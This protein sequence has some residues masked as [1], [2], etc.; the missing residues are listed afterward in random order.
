MFCGIGPRSCCFVLTDIVIDY[1]LAARLFLKDNLHKKRDFSTT[2]YDLRI[3]AQD[4]FILIGTYIPS[5]RNTHVCSL[6]FFIL[7]LTYT[8][9][10]LK[11]FITDSSVSRGTLILM[12]YVQ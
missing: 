5:V 9:I 7:W 4:K 11:K 2:F 12:Y 10:F 3:T 6:C 8:Y 1:L